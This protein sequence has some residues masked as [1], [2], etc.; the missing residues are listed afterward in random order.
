MD[1]RRMATA[2]QMRRAIEL[3]L[4][5]ATLPE[6]D[7]LTVAQLY[8]PWAV[9]RSYPAGKVIKHGEDADGNARLYSVVQAHMSQADWQP[10]TTP[11]LYKRIGFTDGGIPVWT[12]PL[13]AT[14]AYAKGDK[15]S[16]GGSIWISDTDGN[17]WEPGVYGWRQA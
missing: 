8:E 1:D 5:N 16:H 12:Q 6:E 15:V 4:Q 11:A 13:G 3:L 10:D 17:V 7:A 9:D 14:D 2:L